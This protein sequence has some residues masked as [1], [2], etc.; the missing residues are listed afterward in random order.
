MLD[1]KAQA[2]RGVGNV[3]AAVIST[4]DAQME[5]FTK[6][7]ADNRSA[8]LAAL[9]KAKTYISTRKASGCWRISPTS[10]RSSG[11]LA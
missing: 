11:P 7:S 4:D 10:T 6:R 3:R 9:A 5:E 8:A 2:I 1:A